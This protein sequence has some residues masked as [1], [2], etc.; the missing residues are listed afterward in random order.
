VLLTIEAIYRRLGA[1]LWARLAAEVPAVDDLLP[2]SGKTE[3]HLTSGVS[4]DLFARILSVA[5]SLAGRGDLA[6]LTELGEAVAQ[7]GLRRL[8]PD[9]PTPTSADAIVDGFGYLWSRV[10]MQGSTQ[11]LERH[12]TSARLAIREQLEPSLELSGFFAGLMRAAIRS[13]GVR[14]S[15]V[16]LTSCQALG[17]AIDVYGVSWTP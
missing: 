17:D 3:L 6:L 9:L 12:A 16:F 10:T 14:R 11:E 15:E 2:G 5:D 1:D 8:F 7:R 13:T 4:V